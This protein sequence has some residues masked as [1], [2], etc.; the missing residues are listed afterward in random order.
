MKNPTPHPDAPLVARAT[1]LAAPRGEV[2]VKRMFGGFGLYMEGAMFAIVGDGALWLKADAATRDDFERVGAEVFTYMRRD[3][4]VSLSFW[5]VPE[6]GLENPDAFRPWL[7]RAVDA[8]RRTKRQT[9]APKEK[10]RHR[11]FAP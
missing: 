7:D 9:R 2:L 6:G 5:T 11:G 10:R 1:M 8:A 3:R 4:R